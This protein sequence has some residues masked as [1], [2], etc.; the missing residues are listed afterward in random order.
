MPERPPVLPLLARR[1]QPDL[2][3]RPPGRRGAAGHPPRPGRGRL[4]GRAAAAGLPGGAGGLPGPG[5]RRHAG[6]GQDQ[7]RGQDHRPRLRRADVPPLGHLGGRQAQPPLPGQGRGRRTGR[8]DARPGRRRAH[9]ALGRLRRD[10]GHARRQ[11]GAVH[12]EGAA[13]QRGGLEHRLRHLR[14]QE[15]RLRHHA[16]PERGQRGL[17]HRA[18]VHPRRQDPGLAGHGAPGLRGRQLPPPAH[19]LGHRRGPPPGRGVHHAAAGAAHRPL[20]P[21][22]EV[23]GGQPHRLLLRRQPGP[24]LDLQAGHQVGPGHAASTRWARPRA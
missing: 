16:L 24:E 19:G 3:H 20:A 14:G 1:Q 22:A 21:R 13:R 2:A 6:K 15:R 5:H 10:R 9:Q 8:P 7:G 18:L 17:G 23:R 11:R 12:G 4:L